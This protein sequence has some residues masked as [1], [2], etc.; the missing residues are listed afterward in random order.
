MSLKKILKDKLGKNYYKFRLTYILNSLFGKSYI[1]SRKKFKN[2]TS[3]LNF[4]KKKLNKKI[5]NKKIIQKESGFLIDATRDN[6]L[7]YHL[8]PKTQ[9]ISI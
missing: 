9:K 1:S 4:F 3:N 2:F 7:T 5:E 8:R 6:Y